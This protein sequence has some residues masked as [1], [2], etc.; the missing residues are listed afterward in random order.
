L[1]FGP[2]KFFDLHSEI[3]IIFYF[4]PDFTFSRKAKWFTDLVPPVK[5]NW[6]WEEKSG[7]T[8]VAPDMWQRVKEGGMDIVHEM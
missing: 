3:K 2:Y 7:S 6:T 4:G 1:Q 8:D 5:S